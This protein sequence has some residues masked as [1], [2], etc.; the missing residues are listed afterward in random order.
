MYFQ[1][2]LAA[3][4][5]LATIYPSGKDA[6]MELV[7]HARAPAAFAQDAL[8]GDRPGGI[9]SMNED[10]ISPITFADETSLADLEDV[11]RMVAHELY[12]SL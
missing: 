6:P 1:V 2:H 5:Y 12:H 4:P 9:V 10:K 11:G 8:R 7:S 3:I